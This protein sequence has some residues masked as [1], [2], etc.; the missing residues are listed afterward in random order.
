MGTKKRPV[1]ARLPEK[2]LKIRR[3]LDLTQEQLAERF[4]HLPSAPHPGHISRFEQGLREPNL[5]YLL[6]ISRLSG[7]S[8]E[9][10]LD[11]AQEVPDRLPAR[12]KGKRP[13]S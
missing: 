10:I 9:C 12:A 1:P 8:L 3:L 13:K 5:I 6:E 4:S 11:D 2:L 7:I